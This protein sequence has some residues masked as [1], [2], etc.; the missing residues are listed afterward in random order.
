M[1]IF[2]LKYAKMRS[3]QKKINL[4]LFSKCII[5]PQ[6]PLF[7]F[8]CGAHVSRYFILKFYTCTLHPC[9]HVYYLSD[10]L[11]LKILNFKIFLNKGLHGARSPKCPTPTSDPMNLLPNLSFC[12][13]GTNCIWLDDWRSFQTFS[14]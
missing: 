11:K 4:G 9:I 14:H 3:T 5:H 1:Q 7:C 6:S 10:F 8:F 2:R 13:A 12:V